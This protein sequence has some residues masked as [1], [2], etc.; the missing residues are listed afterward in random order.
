MLSVAKKTN[1]T[2]WRPHHYLISAKAETYRYVHGRQDTNL[3]SAIPQSSTFTFITP[4]CG[5]KYLM[6]AT[7][8]S[9]LG[10]LQPGSRT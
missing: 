7:R 2:I 10:Y 3:G 8:Q 9:A 6:V 5:A 1:N 4:V